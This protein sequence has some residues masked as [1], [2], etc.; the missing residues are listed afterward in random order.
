MT[1]ILADYVDWRG[2]DRILVTTSERIASSLRA[3]FPN[4]GWEFTTLPQ[5]S[6][7]RELSQSS[8][9]LTTAGLVTTQAAYISSTPTIFLPASNN[10]HYMLLDELRDLGLA[11]ASV[12]LADTMERVQIQG[13]PQ[14]ENLPE[15][16]GQLMDL[17]QSPSLRRLVGERLNELVRTKDIW[18]LA[19]V[20]AGRAF[21]SSLEWEGAAE[22]AAHAILDMLP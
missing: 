10:A 20:D 11:S 3:A 19:S 5:E 13:R 17:D 1:S 8:L 21:M 16:L 15:V 4:I 18:E 22:T 6:F 7:T 14:S 9:L 2:F 12:H